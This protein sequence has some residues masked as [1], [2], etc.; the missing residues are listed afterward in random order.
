[1]F[2][3][4]PILSWNDVLGDFDDHVIGGG[5]IGAGENFDNWKKVCK[6]DEEIRAFMMS[7]FQDYQNHLES[8]FRLVK[9]ALQFMRVPAKKR[10][11]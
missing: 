6:E 5:G 11:E 9:R 8:R 1:M 3:V 7:A 2:Y 10:K 4:L